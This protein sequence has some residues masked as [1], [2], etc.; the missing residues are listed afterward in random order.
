MHSKQTSNALHVSHITVFV[1][2]IVHTKLEHFFSLCIIISLAVYDAFLINLSMKAM[3]LNTTRPDLP[4]FKTCSSPSS[5]DTTKVGFKF[6]CIWHCPRRVM[7]NPFILLI[8]QFYALHVSKKTCDRKLFRLTDS[9]TCPVNH[10]RNNIAAN[11]LS[12]V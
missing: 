8:P 7:C 5:F 9:D 4:V 10:V 1:N 6:S 12:R 3:F 2:Q 11:W